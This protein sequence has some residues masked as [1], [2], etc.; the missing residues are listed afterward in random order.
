[1][2]CLGRR[3]ESKERVK[4]SWG[5]IGHNTQYHR[6]GN[7]MDGIGISWVDCDRGSM[8]TETVS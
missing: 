1:M 8:N 7:G 2:G 4:M 5:W 3:D 6:E